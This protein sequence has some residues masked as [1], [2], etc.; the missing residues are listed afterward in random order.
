[1]TVS[2]SEF[3]DALLDPNGAVPA[4]LRDGLGQPAGSR[5]SVYRNNVAV[6]LTEALQLSFPAIQKLLGEENFKSIAGIFLR[7]HPPRTPIMMQYGGDFPDFLHGFKPLAHIGYLADVARLEQAIRTS[8][9]AADAT[10]IAPEFLQRI[11]AEDLAAA[12]FVLSP[13]VQ[14]IRSPWPVHAIWAFNMEDGP[15][16][17]AEAQSVLIMRPEFDPELTPISKGTA[18]FLLA[19]KSGISL[20]DANQTVLDND[21]AFDLSEALGLLLSGQAITQVK[22]GED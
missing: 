7:Q 21:P 17:T 1:M 8:Y 11:P 6:S 14:V 5:F 9:H 12:R 15:K 20:A 2:Q 18:E 10:P 4:G 22:T 3:H 13:S 16:P 19:L